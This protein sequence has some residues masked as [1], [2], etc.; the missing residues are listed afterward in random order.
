MSVCIKWLY[1]L[2]VNSVISKLLTNAVV[3]L[4]AFMVYGLLN[5]ALNWT[6]FLLFRFCCAMFQ[7]FIFF[8]VRLLT[9][10]QGFM[11]YYETTGE[12][13]AVCSSV[14]LWWSEMPLSVADF[15]DCFIIEFIVFLIQYNDIN[16]TICVYY[17]S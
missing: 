11:W 8:S 7:L 5:R 9:T 2:A 16:N 10:R 4:S 17:D 1:D 3:L 6:T 12:E 13:E 14:A 15:G